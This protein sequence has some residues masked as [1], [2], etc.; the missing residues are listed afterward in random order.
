MHPDCERWN[1]ALA[2]IAHLQRQARA[3]LSEL[4]HGKP[5]ARK[6]STSW[7]EWNLRCSAWLVELDELAQCERAARRALAALREQ[8]R[9]AA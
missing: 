8:H 6:N 9:Q 1:L 3:A 5:E 4:E 7:R 2:G